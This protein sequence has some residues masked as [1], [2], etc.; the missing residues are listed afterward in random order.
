MLFGVLGPLRV[1]GDDGADITP[2]GEQQRRALAVLVASAPAPV[3]VATLE[4]LLWRGPPPSANALQALVSKLRK[5]VAPVRIES[6]GRGYALRGEFETD[7]E[8]LAR[9]VAAG[10]HDEAERLVRGEPLIDL[11]DLP[12]SAADR[13]RLAE[14]VRAAKHKRIEAIV[15]GPNPID[16]TAE[17][18]SLVVTEPLDE[19]WWALLMRV[20]HRRG[21]QAEAL[22]TFQRA[23]RLL[24]DELGLSP[25]PELQRLERAILDGEPPPTDRDTVRDTVPLRRRSRGSGLPAR[26]SSFVGREADLAALAEAI[27]GHRLVTLVGPGGTGKTTTALELARRSAGDEAAFLQLAPLVDYDSIGRALTTAIGLPESE[28]TSFVNESACDDPLDRVVAALADATLTLVI[29]NCEHV[30]EPAAEIVHR[31]LVECPAVTVIATSRSTLAVP[32]ELVYPLPPL[33][34]DEAIELFVARA[35]DHAAAGAVEAADPATLSMLVDRLDR[36]PLAIELAAARLRSMSIDELIDRLDDRFSVLSA[37]P[38]TV[39][40]RQQTLRAVVDWSHQLLEPEEQV[41]FRRLS[42][43][44][45]GASQEAVEF[46][47]GGNDDS[48][49]GALRDVV[50]RL[51][52]QSLIRVEHTPSGTRYSMLET[53]RDYALERLADSG[54]RELV[55]TRHAQYYADLL[56]GAMRGVIGHGQRQWLDLIARER[57]NIDVARELA[58]ARQEAQLAL[59]LVAPLGWYF[60][61]TGQ[62]DSGT[63]AFADALSCPGPTDPELRAVALGLYGWLMSNGPNV[64]AAVNFT[65]E[66]LAMTDRIGDPWARGVIANTHVMALFFAG[67]TDRVWEMLPMLEQLVDESGDPWVVAVTKVVRGELL[68][69]AGKPEAAERLL[70]EAAEDFE[71]VGDRFAYALTITEASEIAEMFG[72]Y[73]RAAEMLERG[74]ALADEVGFSGHPLAM[75]SRL[76]NVELLR[77]NIDVADRHQQ[78]LIDDPVVATVPWLLSMALLGK[79]AIARRRGEYELADQ[80]LV[81]AWQL[82]R[83]KSSPL[84]RT[85]VLVARGYLADQVG[86]GRRALEFQTDALRT[87]VSLGVPRHLAYALEGCAGALAIQPSGEHSE[88]GAQLLGAADR[89]RR[90]SGGPMPSAER[91][92]VDRA[93]Q[94]LRTALGDEAFEAALRAGADREPKDL[95]IA[96]EALSLTA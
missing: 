4:E 8:Q 76:G 50:D 78:V 44:V 77:G 89:L 46:V 25:G 59:E 60:Y 88:L 17:L 71:L 20:H 29:D 34:S 18:E 36:L 7:V 54:E 51:L 5:V 32:G 82:P 48:R 70:F 74:I 62:L 68:Q 21:Q 2:R 56:K 69:F 26:L 43:F 12:A 31:L 92:D 10:A 41:V 1:I 19:G 86:D 9:C 47:A 38:R 73:D 35:R 63:D 67:M 95:V 83:S 30:I 52:D 55:L 84:M 94:R 79:S 40:P 87:A 93:E 57:Q 28:Q 85:L 42:V 13:A 61:M 16:A 23:R 90:N 33:P 65:S 45:G 91:F 49:G 15:E 53:L 58:V 6:D 24:A 72:D 96:V 14:M 64:E 22:R 37:G 3:S 11:A 75:R 81:R 39:E 66:A 80:L 27:A